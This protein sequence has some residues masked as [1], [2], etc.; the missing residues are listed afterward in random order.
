MPVKLAPERDKIYTTSKDIL[1]SADT[2]LFV[3][4]LFNDLYWNS[5]VD[6]FGMARNMG[7]NETKMYRVIR[8]RSTIDHFSPMEFIKILDF[9]GYKLEVRILPK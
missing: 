3:A 9:F 4:K 1:V 2:R 5:D 7:V 6:I 8:G